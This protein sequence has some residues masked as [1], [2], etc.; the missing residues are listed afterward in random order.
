MIRIYFRYRTRLFHEQHLAGSVVFAS[1]EAVEIYATAEGSASVVISFKDDAVTSIVLVF[2]QQTSHFL[3]FDVI[4]IQA[5][6]A[7]LQ[8][9][10]V[11]CSAGVEGVRAVAFQC[12]CS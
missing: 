10:V 11:D 3:T 4:D 5:H 9:I 8:D 1:A 2:I 7:G 6:V 12:G